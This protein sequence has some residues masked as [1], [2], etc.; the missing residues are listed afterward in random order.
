ML[1]LHQ[2]NVRISLKYNTHSLRTRFIAR[3]F[4]QTNQPPGHDY[5]I[6][7]IIIKYIMNACAAQKK[8]EENKTCVFVVIF[9]DKNLVYYLFMFL[10]SAEFNF[11]RYMFN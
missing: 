4:N 9:R 10:R 7:Y 5:I 11:R 6:I 1:F 2:S 3:S 8:F